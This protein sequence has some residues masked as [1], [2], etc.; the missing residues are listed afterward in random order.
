M[1]IRMTLELS[2]PTRGVVVGECFYSIAN[3]GWTYNSKVFD[4]T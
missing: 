3:C 4:E 2:A 1:P